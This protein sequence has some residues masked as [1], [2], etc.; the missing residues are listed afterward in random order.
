MI[1]KYSMKPVQVY[2]SQWDGANIK[3]MERLLDKTSFIC[4][5]MRA[6][7]VATLIIAKPSEF[8]AYKADLGSYLIRYPSGKFEIIPEKDFPERFLEMKTEPKKNK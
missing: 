6:G 4:S 1:K 3:E 7:N 8:K 2:A 5:V